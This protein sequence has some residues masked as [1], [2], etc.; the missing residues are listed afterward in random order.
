MF[1]SLLDWTGSMYARP[2]LLCDQGKAFPGH[3]TKHLTKGKKC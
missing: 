2:A 3:P 1:P